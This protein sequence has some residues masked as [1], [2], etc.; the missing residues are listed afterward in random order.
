MNDGA[1]KAVKKLYIRLYAARDIAGQM[2]SGSTTNYPIHEWAYD[3][4][5][6]YPILSWHLN[7]RMAYA[8]HS[9]NKRSRAQR[10]FLPVHVTSMCHT[11][12]VIYSSLA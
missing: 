9:E 8:I 12:I 3:L 11:Q 7:L 1:L 5:G 2:C 4:R 6:S 10:F